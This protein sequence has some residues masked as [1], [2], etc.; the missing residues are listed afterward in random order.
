MKEAVIVSATRTPVGKFGGALKDLSA[1]K[2]GAIAVREAVRRARIEPKDIEECIMGNVITAGLGQNPARQA[3]LW[4]GLTDEVAALTINK[5]C[6]SG[7]KA[8]ML[9]ADAILAGK[10]K[11]IVA[12]GMENMTNAPYLLEKA[13]F[14]YKL[15]DSSL[16]D[17]M[18]RDGLWE[19]YNNYHMGNTGEIV[20]QRN[21]VTRADADKFALWSHQKSVAA[22]KSGA[23][24]E[25]I[26]HVELPLKKEV[27]IF[28][29]DE[30]PREDTS[31]EALA[32]LKPVFKNDGVLTAGNSSSINDGASAVVVMDSELAKERGIKPLV[33]IVDYVTSG[34]K[35]ELLM[36]API[37]AV[38]KLLERN[39]L[40]VKDID[41]WEHNEA[42]STASVA[43]MKVL[44]IPEDKF[45]VNGGAV[46][47]GHPIGCSGARVLTTL[48]YAM[49]AHG[50]RRGIATLCLGGG[51]AVAMLVER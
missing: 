13:R 49:R 16:V 9:A 19:V 36:E 44:G 10:E 45:N 18:V 32:K 15:F 28:S 26:V 33:K 48:I 14:G 5:V 8:V 6:G 4:G 35:P 25:E 30:G 27:S 50:S 51:N 40:E 17:S 29:V 2:I 24:K 34:V 22:I 21:G 23:F 11:A 42:F 3:A 41:L 43:I 39:G 20:A 46:A 12:G 31:L 37:H 38:R 7:L 47:L 1:P